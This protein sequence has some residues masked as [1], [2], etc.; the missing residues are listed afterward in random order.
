MKQLYHGS[1]KQKVKIDKWD[2]T[3]LKSFYIAKSS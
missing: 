3:K 2:F 1:R